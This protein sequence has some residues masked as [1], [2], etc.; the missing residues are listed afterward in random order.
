MR[1]IG[2]YKGKRKDTKKW[3]YGSLIDGTESKYILI[4]ENLSKGLDIGG[5]F[6]GQLFEIIPETASQ[7]TGLKDKN[8]LNVYENDIL[9]IWTVDG[10]VKCVVKYDNED[11]RFLFCENGGG[12]M[13]NYY[14]DVSERGII[15]GNIF[16]NPELLKNN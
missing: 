11:C 12:G 14:Y 5:W 10:C 1:L 15:I 13:D 3:V 4:A 6:E 7:F 16:D 9:L 8:K 2:L